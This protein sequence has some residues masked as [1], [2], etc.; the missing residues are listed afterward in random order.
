VYNE[1]FRI[2]KYEKE[3]DKALK[4]LLG[5]RYKSSTWFF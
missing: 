5:G 4:S 1:K 2:S 3:Q